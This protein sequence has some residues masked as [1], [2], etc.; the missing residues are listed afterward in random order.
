MDSS[1][2]SSSFPVSSHPLLHELTRPLTRPRAIIRE[3]HLRPS[4]SA[5]PNVVEARH[6][7]VRIEPNPNFVRQLLDNFSHFCR[8]HP[9]RGNDPILLGGIQFARRC[10]AERRIEDDGIRF[11]NPLVE[12][13]RGALEVLEPT[14]I[15]FKSERFE[16][17]IGARADGIWY[18]DNETVR[19]VWQQKSPKS[20]KRF[21]REIIDAAQKRVSFNPHNQTFSDA[22]SII[23]KV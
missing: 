7:P 5:Y 6:I 15:E 22:Q 1:G 10:C 18:G 21:F 13:L 19:V 8:Q 2:S 17:L 3:P 9:D 14:S 20:S 11:I 16:R 12:P 23:V 4:T